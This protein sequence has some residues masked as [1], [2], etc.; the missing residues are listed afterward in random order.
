[1]SLFMPRRSDQSRSYDVARRDGALV[2]AALMR[3]AG[4]CV[5]G[6]GGFRLYEQIHWIVERI[7]AKTLAKR[8]FSR[9]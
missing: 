2:D 4:R 1:M 5:E 7:L 8:S 9:W 3:A 6:T